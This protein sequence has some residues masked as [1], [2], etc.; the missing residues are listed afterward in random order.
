MYRK[1]KAMSDGIE[2]HGLD[3]YS[4][5][6]EEVRKRYPDA[7]EA[8][9][10][11]LGN[12]FK[13]KVIEKTPEGKGKNDKYKLKKSYHLSSTKQAGST[14][15]LEF[16][17]SSPHFH[18]VER[19]HRIVDKD[20]KEHGFKSGVHMVENSSNEFEEEMPEDVEKWLD[21]FTEELG[22]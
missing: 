7:A 5:Q 3:E 16:N 18:L 1:G 9:L 15:F 17:S 6:L 22:K 11:K 19:G 10:R 8:E 14:L 12:K 2:F 13:K 21:K 4:T 20:G